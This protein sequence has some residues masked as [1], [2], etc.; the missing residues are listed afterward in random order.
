LLIKGTIDGKGV[1]D[2]QERNSSFPACP[3]C[4]AAQTQIDTPNG[5]IAVE[6]LKIGDV[7]W[8]MDGSSARVSMPI[9]KM[10]RVNVPVNHTMTH[11]LLSDGRELWV[12]PGHPTADGRRIGDLKVGDLLDRA[13]VVLLERVLYDQPAT[14]DLLPSG[15]TGFYWANGIL[16]DST[17]VVP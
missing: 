6:D 14:Y 12:S 1:I 15:D 5:T 13:R 7:V 17:L 10:A 4:L 2:V 11:L 8:T 9:L 16:L 3:I